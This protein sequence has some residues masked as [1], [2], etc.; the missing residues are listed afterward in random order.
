MVVLIR[1]SKEKSP[2]AAAVNDQRERPSTAKR[3]RTIHEFR[4]PSS[5]AFV[6]E[7]VLYLFTIVLISVVLFPA[8]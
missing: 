4:G 2:S 3:R 8:F 1:W 7:Q 6:G 5:S